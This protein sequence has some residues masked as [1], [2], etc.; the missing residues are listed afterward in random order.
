MFVY[1]AN[2]ITGGLGGA[3]KPGL[4][5]GLPRYTACP[6]GCKLARIKDSVCGS[7]Y[8]GNGN[9]N[10]P[11][12]TTAQ[13]RR[14]EAVK[15][16]SVEWVNAMVFLINRSNTEYFRW[17]DS[18]DIISRE[19]LECIMLV[20][21]GTPKVSHWLPTKERELIYDYIDEG[22]KFPKNMC[23]RLSGYWIDDEFIDYY[24]G[25]PTANV[26]RDSEPQG[27]MC[28]AVLNHSSC[29]ECNCRN[30]WNNDFEMVW[31]KWH[32]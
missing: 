21:Y 23:V 24:C 12:V 27:Y 16:V 3:S 29:A 7:C 14:Y 2:A 1:E 9:Y 26:Y 15:K 10:Y 22:N 13:T 18:G 5:Y 4:C 31:Y 32:R 11:S 8:A 20:A 17:H 30:C 6:K 28:P 19:Y 25:L